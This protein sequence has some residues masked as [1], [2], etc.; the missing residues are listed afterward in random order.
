MPCALAASPRKM[1]PPPMTT[2]TSTPSPRTSA[3]SDAIPSSVAGSMPNPDCPMSASPESLSRIRLKRGAF[4]CAGSP[5]G[6]E[7]YY[8]LTRRGRDDD[9]AR[10]HL[11]DRDQA[12]R[13][14]AHRQLG[15]RDQAGAG[16][17]RAV[18]DRA[19]LHRRLSRAHVGERSEALR[20]TGARGG[21]D[22]ARARAR[23]Q[24]RDLLPAV[25]SARGV[26][27]VLGAVVHDRQGAHEPRAR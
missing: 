24:A 27:A 3:I 10:P 16:A 14:A 23:S 15:R 22:L 13:D 17:G 6:S 20:A 18:A 19:V 1:L 5:M 7:V 2:A 21:G 25:G 9:D 12:D 4:A 11:P 8:S 26:R